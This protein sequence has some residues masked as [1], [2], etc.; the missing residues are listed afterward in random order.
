MMQPQLADTCP[1]GHA[2]T[3]ELREMKDALNQ[4]EGQLQKE[5]PQAGGGTDDRAPGMTAMR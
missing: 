4:P 5:D 1:H 3:V 2:L